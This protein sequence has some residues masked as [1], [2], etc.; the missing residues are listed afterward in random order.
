VE[1]AAHTLLVVV[2]Q[3][4]LAE[5]LVKVHQQQEQQLNQ[6]SQ[7]IQEHMDLVV[8]VEL[9]LQVH[10]L[11]VTQAVEE[12]EELEEMEHLQLWEMEEQVNQ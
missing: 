6:H 4:V 9:E 12:Q 3:E 10:Q 8:Q 2:Y 1:E 11:M 7:E 5:V